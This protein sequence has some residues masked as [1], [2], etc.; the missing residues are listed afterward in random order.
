M[1]AKIDIVT[2]DWGYLT[3]VM[4]MK[5]R[6]VSA[7]GATDLE[8]GSLQE[9]FTFEESTL[10]YSLTRSSTGSITTDLSLT[11]FQT[12]KPERKEIDWKNFDAATGLYNSDGDVG[13]VPV[14]KRATL[15]AWLTE[16]D[17]PNQ[18]LS[19]VTEIGEA[20]PELSTGGGF[21]KECGANVARE[22]HFVGSVA[23]RPT[24]RNRFRG[25]TGTHETVGELEV[26]LREPKV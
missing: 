3:C 21:C 18:D 2:D 8:L 5:A 19:N 6:D 13:T 22:Q 20:T 15:K 17:R 4:L 7:T 1:D 23:R 10:K 9:R 14:E 25:G 16:S 26:H 11:Y 12:G 24:C